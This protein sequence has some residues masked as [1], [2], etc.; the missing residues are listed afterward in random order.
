MVGY[1]SFLKVRGGKGGMKGAEG[2]WRQRLCL[3]QHLERGGK[4][5]GEEGGELWSARS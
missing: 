1:L 4:G 5:G 3:R 2:P